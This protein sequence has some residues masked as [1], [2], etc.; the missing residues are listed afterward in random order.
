VAVM[1]PRLLQKWLTMPG[2]NLSA[3][4]ELQ[5]TLSRCSFLQ[6]YRS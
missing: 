2:L 5:T 6:K 4:S 3:L 1:I